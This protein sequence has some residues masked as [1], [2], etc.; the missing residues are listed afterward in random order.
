MAIEKILFGKNWEYFKKRAKE[1]KK[2]FWTVNICS[3]CKYKCG[4]I[5]QDDEVYY[6]FGCSCVIEKIKPRKTTWEEVANFYN[7][8]VNKKINKYWKL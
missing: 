4:Y 8:Q 2:R 6:N 5:F 7:T 3:F 1:L